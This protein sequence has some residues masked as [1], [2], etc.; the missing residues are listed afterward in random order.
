MPAALLLQLALYEPAPNAILSSVVFKQG[1]SYV[2][3]FVS[4]LGSLVRL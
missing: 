3:Y 2:V 4:C 1:T